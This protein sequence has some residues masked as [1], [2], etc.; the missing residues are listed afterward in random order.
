MTD[1]TTA[2][3]ST[4]VVLTKEERI[5]KL[6]AEI[7]KLE[8]KIFNI[9]NNI[10]AVKVKKEVALP[11]QGAEILFQYGRRTAT[12]EPVQKLGTVVAVKPAS[13]SEGGKKLPAQI[14]VSIGE[15]FDQEFVIIYPAQV[16]AK[17][18]TPEADTPA[19]E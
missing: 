9:E 17:Q 15:G 13:L 19:A 10:V 14:K 4:P 6:R 2:T 11:V 1:T 12:T 8:T 16:V 18:P 5:A 3:V 7:V